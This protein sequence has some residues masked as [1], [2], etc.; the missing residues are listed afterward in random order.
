MKEKRLTFALAGQANVGK[1][2][3]FNQLTGLHQHIGNWPGKTVERAEGTLHHEGYTIDIIDLPGIYSLSTFSIEEMVSREYIA[4]KKPDV[5]VN[6][7]DASILERNL[8]FTV[9][10]LELETPMILVLNQFDMTK[11]KG[12]KIDIEK[13]KNILGI[14]VIPTIATKGVGVHEVVDEAMK[15]ARKKKRPPMLKYGNEIE[16]R[17]KRL[18]SRIKKK[19]IQYPARWVA[20]KLLEGDEEI[21][22]VVGRIDGKILSMADKMCKEIEKIHGHP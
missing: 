6:V 15:M 12:I 8:F 9:Q 16:K 18:V 10:L 22:K 7:A 11:K 4:V 14:P 21:K 13:L 2:V 19:D 1:S 17:L 20:I 5:V 3:L